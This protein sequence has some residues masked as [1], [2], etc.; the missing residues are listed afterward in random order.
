MRYATLDT[1]RGV[2][3]VAVFVYHLHIFFGFGFGQ[4]GYFGVDVFFVVSGFIIY[5]NLSRHHVGLHRP[6]LS[7]YFRRFLRLLVPVF[8]LFLFLTPIAIWGMYR[9]SL[10]S[11][12][13]SFFPSI[14]FVANYYFLVTSAGYMSPSAITIPTMHLWSIAVEAQFYLLFPLLF[15][16]IHKRSMKAKAWVIS[17]AILLSFFWGNFASFFLTQYSYFD[18]ASRFWQFLLG[19]LVALVTVKSRNNEGSRVIPLFIFV[20]LLLV[21][22]VFPES[23]WPHPGLGS[24]PVSLLAALLIFVSVRSSRKSE[25]WEFKR[26]QKVGKMSFSIYLWHYPILL[27]LSQLRFENPLWILPVA[28]LLTAIASVFS[29]KIFEQKLVGY[30]RLQTKARL[31]S[32]REARHFWR[33]W[34]AFILSASVFGTAAVNAHLFLGYAGFEEEERKFEIDVVGRHCDISEI[35]LA[36]CAESQ[37]KIRGGPSILIVGDSMVPSTLLIMEAVQPQARFWFSSESACPPLDP[38][39]DKVGSYSID[40]LSGASNRFSGLRSLEGFDILV[41]SSG[42]RYELEDLRNFISYSRSTLGFAGKHIFIGPYLRSLYPAADYSFRYG[43]FSATQDRIV[44]SKDPLFLRQNPDSEYFSPDFYGR[45]SSANTL[46]IEPLKDFCPTFVNCQVVFGTS[47]FAYDTHHWT[48]DFR[49]EFVRKY[50][51]KIRKF[52]GM[53]SV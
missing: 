16:L 52:I 22:F 21:L 17:S 33:S 32:P 31:G 10:H 24:A 49:K 35:A 2:A 44:F 27:M 40:C 48:D 14:T 5:E 39:S 6:L 3:T 50:G 28:V 42:G 34:G 53:G 29:Y 12:L 4:S 51:N 23:E 46:V 11:L 7:F 9:S 19:V 13:D 37:D 1:L 8:A 20:S 47:L 38:F 26:L 25:V 45:L 41:V 15:Y 43:S 30:F 36:R 18:T